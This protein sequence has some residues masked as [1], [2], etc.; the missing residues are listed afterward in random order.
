MSVFLQISRGIFALSQRLL[1]VALILTVPAA[2]STPQPTNVEPA[3]LQL[4]IAEPDTVVAMIVQKTAPLA[5][6]A[7][8]IELGGRITKELSLINAFVV[9]LPA[10]RIAQMAQLPGVRWVSEDAPVV[11]TVCA[12]CIGTAQ[13]ASVYNQAIGADQLWNQPPY[14]QGQ[15]IGIAVLDSGIQN[16]HKDVAGRIV[17]AKNSVSIDEIFKLPSS[18]VL[19]YDTY[20]H[21][22]FV[23]SLI[24]GNGASAAGRYVGVAPRS[25]LI[26]VR[27][28]SLMGAATESDVVAG[29]QWV[30]ENR[31]AYNIRVANLS[32][33][34]SKASSYATSPLSAACEILWFNGVVV[35]TSAG[36]RGEG[37]I[38]P[39]ANDP[40]VITVGAAD[41]KGT[42]SIADDVVAHFSAFGATAEGIKKPDL[43]APG[44]YIVGAR[45][46]SSL[47][48]LFN[49]QMIV[50]HSYMRMS[51]TSAAAPIV[52][53][54]VALLLQNEPHL[55][56]D[57]VKQRLLSTANRNW[58]G[59]NEVKAGAG[60]LDI[61]AAVRA[62]P[63]AGVTPPSANTGVTINTLI[64]GGLNRVTELFNGVATLVWDSVSWSSVS[65]S[66]V[67]WSSVSW[68]SVSW[69][70]DYIETSPV[71]APNRS[72]AAATLG[73]PAHDPDLAAILSAQQAS[74]T[75]V[76]AEESDL[77]AHQLFLPLVFDTK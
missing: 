12:D 46:T 22:T 52:S 75:A 28:S 33:N 73:E 5:V 7:Q 19:K 47:L 25:Q 48:T 64:T 70:S 21:G 4:A 61:A 40:F 69:S 59:Y 16:S 6:E 3:L 42:P 8:V 36:N 44:R 29:L 27:V 31:T 56:P 34:A 39:P 38:Y 72:L 62:V 13:L 65:W 50:D 30:Y 74:N 24:A 53:G 60:Y 41:D 35:V 67:S 66:S 63:V 51:G 37:T 71:G 18:E 1:V 26:N 57:Q 20:G 43:V 32:F 68:S 77:Q 9:E 11:E 10:R 55:T 45:A 49:P 14:L 23:A 76:D 2:T 54:A 15:G 17:A 58:S